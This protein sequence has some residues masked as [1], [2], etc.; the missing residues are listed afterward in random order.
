MAAG[1]RSFLFCSHIKFVMIVTGIISTLQVAHLEKDITFYIELGFK[2]DWKW[3]EKDPT[4]A[5]ISASDH[6]FMLAVVDKSLHIEKADL[7][8]RVEDVENLYKELSIKKISM[9]ALTQTDYGMLDFSV[10]S[11][12]GHHLVFGQPSGDWQE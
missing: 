5:S 12:N 4:Q 8:F 7:H 1:E 3:P 2:L 9:G 6:S 10:T 11:L